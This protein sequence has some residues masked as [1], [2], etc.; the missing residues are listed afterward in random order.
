MKKVK[1]FA[2]FFAIGGIGYAVIELIWRG[3]TH[4]TMVLAGGI[5]FV[6]FSV[7]ADKMKSKPLIIKLAACALSITAVELIFGVIFNI[8]LKMNVWDYSRQPLNFLGQICPLFTLLWGVLSLF[9]FPL[10]IY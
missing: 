9:Y 5:C 2:V 3:F 1:K 6:I 7:I 8:I 4:W 10:P